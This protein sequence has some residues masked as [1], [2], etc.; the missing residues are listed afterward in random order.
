MTFAMPVE[1]NGRACF[2]VFAKHGRLSCATW[3]KSVLRPN[4]FKPFHGLLRPVSLP[5][6]QIPGPHVVHNHV[7]MV[8]LQRADQ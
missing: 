8:G 3:W 6:V 4:F 2:P 7:K 5:A 1:V